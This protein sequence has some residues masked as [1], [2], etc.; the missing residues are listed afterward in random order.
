MLYETP[1]KCWSN[2]FTST[3]LLVREC[4]SSK[5]LCIAL[6]LEC[7]CQF[8]LTFFPCISLPWPL[9]YVENYCKIWF[10]ALIVMWVVGVCFD[11][12]HWILHLSGSPPGF[13]S[14]SLFSSPSLSSLPPFSLFLFFPFLLLLFFPFLPLLSLLFLGP[15]SSPLL[16]LSLSPFFL[17]SLFFPLARFFLCPPFLPFLSPPFFFPCSSSSLP[18][19]SFFLPLSPSSFPFPSP[20][21]FPLL[22]NT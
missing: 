13:F 6:G 8:F 5:K 1:W 22:L 12:L 11:M 4:V 10:F 9:S 14:L 19:F 20:S 15:F 18:L 7:I 16:G 3:A 2:I 21:S 17:F